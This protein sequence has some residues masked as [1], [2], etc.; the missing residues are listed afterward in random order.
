MAE[1]P[2][3][4]GGAR[5]QGAFPCETPPPTGWCV[6]RGWLN[7]GMES[8]SRIE[9]REA[10]S[11]LEDIVIQRRATPHFTNDPVPGEVIDTALSVATQAPSGYNLQPWRFLVLT[12][13]SQR[14]RL[15]AA[16]SG[17]RKIGEAPLMIVALARRSDWQKRAEEIFR[18]RA[19]RTG[20][21]WAQAEP[22]LREAVAFV[23]KLPPGVWENRQTMIAFTYL[24]L[25]FEFQGWDT[26]P[27]EDFDA[28]AV[29]SAFALPA[30]TEVIALLAVGRAR[31]QD[32]VHP[33]RL[34]VSDIAYREQY[35]TPYVSHETDL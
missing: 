18:T 11:A 15:Q 7:W 35:G 8:L 31:D 28:A 13:A 22:T 21:D 16:A 3:G 5:R 12:E 4:R 34:P 25:A 32:P 23:A 1:S 33:G 10:L 30:D 17:Q 19:A 24:M 26:A 6:V 27:M 29:R 14:K 9:T 2:K 20:A